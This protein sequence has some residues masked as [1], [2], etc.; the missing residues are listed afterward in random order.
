MTAQGEW[1]IVPSGKHEGKWHLSGW[2]LSAI[3]GE[4]TGPRDDGWLSYGCC[5]VC[6]AMVVADEQHPYG[7]LT[8]AHEQWHASTDY[9]IPAAAAGK[10]GKR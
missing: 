1:Y 10:D 5:P 3:K 9:P 6:F 7:D 8:W 4:R 2:M